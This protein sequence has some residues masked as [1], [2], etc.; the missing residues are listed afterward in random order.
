MF[1]NLSFVCTSPPATNYTPLVSLSQVSKY[2]ITGFNHLKCR[3]LK[4]PRR[5]YKA[6]YKTVIYS[7]R[8]ESLPGEKQTFPRSLCSSPP[9]E[10]DPNASS[11]ALSK[12]SVICRIPWNQPA[13]RSVHHMTEGHMAKWGKNT[14]HHII[15]ESTGE[16]ISNST[17]KILILMGS[18]SIRS[19]WT[20][21]TAS[22][23]CILQTH[24]STT[25][26]Q[27]HN[28]KHE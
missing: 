12:A 1:G 8:R 2:Y 23:C 20:Y 5:S 17:S 4:S 27:A 13:S 11:T 14:S 9:G 7:N 19:I 6:G 21:L 16:H 22:P 18:S 3:R 10:A 25:I 15:H 24:I 26:L 28:Y